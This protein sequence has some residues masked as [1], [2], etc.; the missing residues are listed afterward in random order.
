ML[1][2][3][4]AP[5]QGRFLRFGTFTSLDNVGHLRILEQG[6]IQILTQARA[7]GTRGLSDSCNTQFLQHSNVSLEKGWGE[8]ILFILIYTV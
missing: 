3:I 2:L 8:Y 6:Q 7:G 1:N 5:G 4:F